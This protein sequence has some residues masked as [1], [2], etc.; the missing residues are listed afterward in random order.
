[1]SGTLPW[2]TAPRPSGPTD[3]NDALRQIAQ[4]T[5]SILQWMKYLTFAVILLIVVTALLYV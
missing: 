1:M 4:N 2:S 5:A 3:P